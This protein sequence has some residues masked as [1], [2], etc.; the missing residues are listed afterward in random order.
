MASISQLSPSTTT[1]EYVTFRECYPRIINYMSEHLG[2]VCDKLF[3]KGYISP[4]VRNQARNASTTK[5]E[6]AQLLADTLI[7]RIEQNPSVFHGF[8]KIISEDGPWANDLV[9]TLKDYHEVEQERQ[10]QTQ[11]VGVWPRD[12]EQEQIK[13]VGVP[14]SDKEQEQIKRVGVT[15]RDKEKEQT[16]DVR[17]PPKDQEQEQTEHAGVTARVEKQEQTQ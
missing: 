3:S 10:E 5:G 16:E 8:I 12:K 13:R 11:C 2:Q 17:V 15:P 6:K 14:P 9:K 4:E 1:P 7:D